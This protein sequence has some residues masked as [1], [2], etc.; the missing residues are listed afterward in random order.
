MKPIILLIV[1]VF[2]FTGCVSVAHQ[3]KESAMVEF[4]SKDTLNLTGKII[5]PYLVYHIVKKL[6]KMD[7]ETVLKLVTDNFIAIENDIKAWSR[8]SGYKINKIEMFDKNLVFHIINISNKEW[9]KRSVEKLAMII[10]D[11]S[12]EKLLS[13]LGLAVSAALSGKQV[14]IFFQGP[15][16]RLLKKGYNASLEG[17]SKPFTR[18]ARKSL[19]DMGH[20]PANEKITQLKEFG[21]VF[22]I[23]GGSMAHFGVKEKDLIF[24]D[25]IIAEY[26]TILEVMD[27]ANTKIILQ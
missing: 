17:L 23:C 12:L 21:S 15:A 19:A 9:E 27:K 7:G 26:F 11:P 16:T 1:A 25:V 4:N 8:M 3:P 24:K 6:K 22:Y 14:H 18:F 5:T 20:L 10:S 2:I 13:P